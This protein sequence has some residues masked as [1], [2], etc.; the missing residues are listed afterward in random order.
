MSSASD[1]IGKAIF[2]DFRAHHGN[3][4]CPTSLSFRVS[5]FLGGWGAFVVGARWL[6]NS[7]SRATAEEERSGG[8]PRSN[9]PENQSLTVAD[10]HLQHAVRRIRQV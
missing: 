7:T 8:S 9:R 1:V 6:G 3:S 4:R 2:V 10:N 5:E